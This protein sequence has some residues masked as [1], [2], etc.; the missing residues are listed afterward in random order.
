MNRKIF[1]AILLVL[2]GWAIL[3]DAL[4]A[5]QYFRIR[6]FFTPNDSWTW[7]HPGIVSFNIGTI[8]SGSVATIDVDGYLS[9][10]F[11]L[12][13]V[14]WATFNHTEWSVERPRIVC[15]EEVFR[16]ITIVCPATGFAWSENA[17]WIALSGSFI[18]LTYSS[19]VYY[20][21]AK[22]L[23]EW[24]WHN[25]ALWYVP[26][27]ALAGATPVD[28]GSTSQTGITLD[29]IGVNF[30]GRIAIV[31]NIAGSR[32][33]NMTNQNVGYVFNSINQA[34]ILNTIR[35]NIA[36]ASRNIPSANLTSGAGIDFLYLKNGSDYYI[37]TLSADPLDTERAVIVEGADIILG[38]QYINTNGSTTDTPKALIAL[39]DENG[40]GGNIIITRDVER[41]YAFI[42]AEWSI[43]SWE[44]PL[45]DPITP[46]I[47]S[48]AWN[49]PAQ[50][51][52]IR[53][54]LISK[55]TIWWALQ[56]PSICPVVIANCT[57]ASA[58]LYD[59]N[60]FRTYDYTD[61]NQES[62][63]PPLNADI[64]FDKSSVIIEYNNSIV[65]DPP[66]GLDSIM[67]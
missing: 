57:I 51:L 53:W 30:I 56:T 28:T 4:G 5:G 21:P 54:W 37:D 10:A 50:Q 58:Q 22:W 33:Y 64:R 45:G 63:P 60:Y 38:K 9:G 3:F 44:K 39:K 40:N 49:I 18:G 24:F 23:L 12:G 27:Y 1:F 47:A 65:K 52:Y 42:Y 32:I 8:N 19:G 34:D 55:N 67:Q 2:L 26:F 17:W 6:W 16:D 20:N 11:W 43:Y 61:P 31:G 62:V 14:G 41:I 59:L 35:K 29:G 25:E 13:T 15:P 46:Y 48:G 7:G 66:P 36:I